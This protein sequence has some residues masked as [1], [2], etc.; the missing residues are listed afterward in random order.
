MRKNKF[1]N[2][3]IG[4]DY[5]KG[6][7]GKK[8]LVV[9]ASFYCPL[10][11]CKNY[12]DC[13]NTESKDSSVFNSICPPYIAD[14]KQLC[15]EP[16]YSIEDKPDAYRIFSKAMSR[17]AG[18]DNYDDIWNKLAFTN[19]VQFF[20]PSDGNSYRQ[21]LPSDL[22]ERDYEAFNE[23]LIE[24]NPDIVII[25]GC[26][27]N[28]RVREQ[29]Q[30]LIDKNELLDTEGYICHLQIPEMDHP[31]AILNCYHPSSGIAWNM[32]LDKFHMYLDKLLFNK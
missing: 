14:G 26:V 20:L 24:I 3:F 9:G 18:T 17:Y 15:D 5:Q 2:P 4:K 30:Y 22:S 7:D 19:Y 12:S 21:T 13:T 8:V 6:F 11:D 31:V 29:N 23:T 27:F 1:F 16:T 10:V 32:G 25:W 28:S